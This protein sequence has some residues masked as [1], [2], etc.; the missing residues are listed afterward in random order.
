MGDAELQELQLNDDGTEPLYCC[1]V[2]S[3][4]VVETKLF[5]YM[6]FFFPLNEVASKYVLCYKLV[7]GSYVCVVKPHVCRCKV[8]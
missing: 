4:I 5:G 2:L 8:E 6:M 3:S 1:K 7:F